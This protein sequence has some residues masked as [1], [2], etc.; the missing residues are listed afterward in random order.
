MGYCRDGEGRFDVFLSYASADDDA[1]NQWVSNFERY[2]N[3][4][5]RAELKRSQEAE[6]DRIDLFRA[7]RDKTGFPPAGDLDT[8]V[9]QSVRYSEFLIIFLGKGYLASKWCLSE[10]DTF[11]QNTGGAVSETLSHLYLIVLD[12]DI[13][14]VPSQ[15]VSQTQVLM[16]LFRGAE[17]WRDPSF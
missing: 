13:F 16:T 15:E 7:C 2:L 10:V 8:V 17:V 12:R 5:V 3:R 6:P 11:R 1:H 9:A 4:M 14:A